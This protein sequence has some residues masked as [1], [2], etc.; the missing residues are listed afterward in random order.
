M[1][2]CVDNYV[3]CKQRQL[4]FLFHSVCLLLLAFLQQLQLPLVLRWKHC[5]RPL[6]KRDLF[7]RCSLSNWGNSL[8]FLTCW[9]FVPWFGRFCKLPFL[10]QLVSTYYF[11]YFLVEMVDYN[12][13]FWNIKLVLHTWN[14]FLLVLVYNYFCTLLDSI[15]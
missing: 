2:V 8:F 1:W 15:C 3:I 7:C 6:N 9:E 5:L 10:Q 11:N 12:D 13:L 4:F 14:K